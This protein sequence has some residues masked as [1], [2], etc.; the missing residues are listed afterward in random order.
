MIMRQIVRNASNDSDEDINPVGKYFVAAGRGSISKVIMKGART[1]GAHVW[2]QD[3][4][5]V[6]TTF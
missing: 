1:G 6:F 3:Y 4:G 5:Y 2:H